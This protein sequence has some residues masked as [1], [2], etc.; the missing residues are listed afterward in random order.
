MVGPGLALEKYLAQ[1]CIMYV[2]GTV[3]SYHVAKGSGLQQTQ[4][5]PGTCTKKS[6]PRVC[7]TYRT[8][9]LSP[10]YFWNAAHLDKSIQTSLKAIRGALWRK[11]TIMLGSDGRKSDLFKNTTRGQQPYHLQYKCQKVEPRWR[12]KRGRFYSGT[13][14]FSHIVRTRWEV[15]KNLF[16]PTKKTKTIFFVSFDLFEY[17]N[18]FL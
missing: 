11:T 16:L 14:W 12:N 18:V 7:S 6:T 8:V 3:C 2:C 15:R 4:E 1:W 13:I 9:C 5:I 17:V 10:C